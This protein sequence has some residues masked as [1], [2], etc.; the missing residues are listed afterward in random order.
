MHRISHRNRN[1]NRNSYIAYTA[2]FTRGDLRASF[3]SVLRSNG[4]P[5]CAPPPENGGLISGDIAPDRMRLRDIAVS[6]CIAGPIRRKESSRA[7]GLLRRLS[8]R[9]KCSEST[10]GHRACT[11]VARV[12]IP[13]RARLDSAC[14]I[15]LAVDRRYRTMNSEL[16]QLIPDRWLLPS[17]LVT[18]KVSGAGQRESRGRTTL[19][20]SSE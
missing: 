5:R 4:P 1:R 16:W 2:A 7:E 9:S 18:A 14:A 13:L 6:C 10:R 3:Y 19:S 11:A 8:E 12:A 20:G 15:A 17:R